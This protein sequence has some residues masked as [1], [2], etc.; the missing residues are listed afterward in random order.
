MSHR[1]SFDQ[2]RIRRT[3]ERGHVCV[4]RAGRPR[5]LGEDLVLTP[6]RTR[7][8]SIAT[9]LATAGLHHRT[10]QAAV[11]GEGREAVLGPQPDDVGVV[12]NDEVVR[13]GKAGRQALG[14]R[15]DTGG[16][17]GHHHPL[18]DRLSLRAGRECSSANGT[19]EVAE[20]DLLSL[21]QYRCCVPGRLH[22][23]VCGRGVQGAGGGVGRQRDLVDPVQRPRQ[24]AVASGDTAVR[25]DR[26]QQSVGGLEVRL[27]AGRERVRADGHVPAQVGQGRTLR[28]SGPSRRAPRR[29]GRP[30]RSVRNASPA[31]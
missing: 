23:V 17:G 21:A 27:S 15:A 16:T 30:R 29:R 9:D 24:F 5:Q 2:S 19:L 18:R 14:A 11:H 10:R 28:A 1:Q 4:S 13:V 6:G 25:Q 22:E 20:D 31:M 3:A 26:T 12:A 7:K 8:C